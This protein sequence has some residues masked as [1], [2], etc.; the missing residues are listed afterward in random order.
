M[1]TPHTET[2]EDGE[3]GRTHAGVGQ[4]ILRE[5]ESCP[6]EGHFCLR[7]HTTA[8]RGLFPKRLLM[9]FLHGKFPE[10]F[11]NPDPH[12]GDT[13]KST[14]KGEERKHCDPILL[15]KLAKT[16]ALPGGGAC[17]GRGAGAKQRRETPRDHVQS[18]GGGGEVSRKRVCGRDRG[19]DSH[20]AHCPPLLQ[21]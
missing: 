11:A 1:C 18:S 10:P 21:P 17:G 3:S 12:H 16:P 6:P 2:F 8:F 9:P 20:V 15:S 19:P 13:T 7:S 14:V 4:D 5:R